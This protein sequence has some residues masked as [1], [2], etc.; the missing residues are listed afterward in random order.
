MGAF[1]SLRP[2]PADCI[3]FAHA[4]PQAGS[5]QTLQ[6]SEGSLPVPFANACID[7]SVEA[8][9]VREHILLAH[10]GCSVLE[11][12]AFV[13]P[14]AKMGWQVQGTIRS[15]HVWNLV[16]PIRIPVGKQDGDH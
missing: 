14:V 6:Q 12:L 3:N 13:K 11:I 8:D 15:G 1:N 5:L 7:C 9:Q 10:P 16:V 2:R 4:R